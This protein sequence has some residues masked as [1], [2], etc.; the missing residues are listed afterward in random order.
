M[1]QYFS[2]K[3][4]ANCSH[5]SE[6]LAIL[7]QIRLNLFLSLY[8]EQK[9]NLFVCLF[10]CLF[11]GLCPKSTT[12]VMAGRSVH[13]T[14]LSWASLNKQLTST[15]CTNFRLLVSNTNVLFCRVTSD[16]FPTFRYFIM[17]WRFDSNMALF[18]CQIYEIHHL[19]L[20]QSICIL[21]LSSYVTVTVTHYLGLVTRKPVLEVSDKASFKPVSSATEI[22]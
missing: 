18:P 1:R 16:F 22:S 21:A 10:V 20:H 4:V 15:S 13:L 8:S 12:M 14:T 6:I 3:I 11:V 2:L 17:I 5:P 7:T 9:S 19:Q